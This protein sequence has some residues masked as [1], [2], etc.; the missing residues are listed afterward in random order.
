MNNLFLADGG[1]TACGYY[2]ADVV[3]Q[4][5]AEELRDR[6]VNLIG[7]AKGFDCETDFSAMIFHRLFRPHQL[8]IFDKIKAAGVKIA[9]E[10]DD[11]LWSVQPYNPAFISFGSCERDVLA[12]TCERADMVIVSTD[13]LA[14]VVHDHVPAANVRVCPNL[15]DNN[16]YTVEDRREPTRILWT[17]SCHHYMDLEVIAPALERI[18]TEMDVQ[19]VFFGDMPKSMVEWTPK[20]GTDYA[21]F[22]P[23]SRFYPKIAYRRGGTL[24]AY[25][26]VLSAM[27]ADIALCPLVD[28]GFNSSKSANKALECAL[29]GA[30]IIATDLPPYQGLPGVTLVPVDGDWYEPI[31]QL[32]L[33]VEKRQRQAG[34]GKIMAQQFWTWQNSA[35]KNIWI[36]TL[37][38][39][40]L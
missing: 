7:P 8:E 2:R 11:D 14:G 22:A 24:E 38:E 40:A 6:G 30:A 17:G 12:Y 39:L 1:P 28:D 9:I 31:K 18:V 20:L 25:P 23:A 21:T 29:T 32:V 16:L 19:L 35:K 37:K 34:V 27:A 10:F 36:E 33:D 15:L 3:A 5:L 26:A 13:H 4:F